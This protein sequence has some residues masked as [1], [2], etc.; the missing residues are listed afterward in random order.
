MSCR[1]DNG[2]PPPADEARVTLTTTETTEDDNPDVE[3]PP[4][5]ACLNCTCTACT[6]Y[7]SKRRSLKDRTGHPPRP[8]APAEQ[9]LPTEA[10]LRAKE[11]LKEQKAQGKKPVKRKK[12]V[13]DGTD[14]CG[15]ALS[16]LGSAVSLLG[17]DLPPEDPADSDESDDADVF[18]HVPKV[19]PDG[20]ADIFSVIAS[21]CY[22][23][24]N[25]VDLLELC[26][27]TAGISKA[28]FL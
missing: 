1:I 16:G 11:R 19:I 26:G 4:T 14:D 12:H 18:Y 23:K 5:P 8:P 7:F 13:E 6:T 22:G 2:P 21:L 24:H 10:R 15:D 27:G 20:T 17:L 28:A 25:S 9:A 3:N